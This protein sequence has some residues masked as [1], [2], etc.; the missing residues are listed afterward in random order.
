MSY[1]LCRLSSVIY[2]YDLSKTSVADLNY[3]KG[4]KKPYSYN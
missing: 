1:A 2:S 3:T 4:I